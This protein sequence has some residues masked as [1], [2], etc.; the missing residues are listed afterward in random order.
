MLKY[1]NCAFVGVLV[2]IQEETVVGGGWEG[3]TPEPKELHHEQEKFK[4]K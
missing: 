1:E 4:N 2:T 3:E